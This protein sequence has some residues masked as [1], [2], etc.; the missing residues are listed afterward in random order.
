MWTYYILVIIHFRF[1]YAAISWHSNFLLTVDVDTKLLASIRH[2]KK[3]S[4]DGSKIEATKDKYVEIE[5]GAY[6]TQQFRNGAYLFSTD[7]RRNENVEVFKQ[8]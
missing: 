6:P 2:K 4:N 7:S 1:L 5:F 3:T 8:R